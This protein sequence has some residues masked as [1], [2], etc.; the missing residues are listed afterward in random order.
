MNAPILDR[1]DALIADVVAPAAA[2]VDRTGAFPTAAMDALR[3]AGFYGLLSSTAVGGLGLGPREAVAVVERLARACAS[4]AMVTCMHF[5][6]AAVIERFGT[7][8]AR[9]A[10]ARGEHLSTLAFSEVGSRSHFWAPLGVARA[11]GDH[12]RLTGAKSWITSAQ[13]A[14]AYVWSS[15]PVA[16]EGASTL[17]LVPR[18]RVGLRVGAGFDGLGLR[19]NDSSPVTA[20]DVTV[21]ADDRLGADGG[22]LA[23]M[24]E[25]VLPLFA[26]M[27]AGCSVGIMER[28]VGGTLTHASATRHQHLGSSLADLP[29]IRAYIARMKIALDQARLLLDDTVSA[30]E[31]GRADTMLRVLQSKA[32][33][34]ESAT[35]VTDLAMR[36]CGGAAFRK[37]LGIERA[38]RDARAAT[39]MAPT[40]DQ[41]YDFLGKALCGLPVF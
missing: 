32:A 24:L 40:T 28:A 34:G 38:F 39:V 31:T 21:T 36:V 25:V 1:L 19:G 11:E 18:D 10:V 2:E 26:A 13:H 33:A 8:A 5:A 3:D 17:W 12:V 4:T 16:A 23:I 20:E 29:T 9:R 27:N 14:T 6:G 37:E 22:G 15:Q 7:E 30:M 35:V 41:L